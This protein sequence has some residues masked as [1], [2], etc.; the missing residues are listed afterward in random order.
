MDLTCHQFVHLVCSFYF[1]D[2]VLY[3]TLFSS[4]LGFVLLCLGFPSPHRSD[5]SLNMNVVA[6]CL[7]HPLVTSASLHLSYALIC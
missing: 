7:E 6:L 5:F 1:F 3:E 4:D 2:T